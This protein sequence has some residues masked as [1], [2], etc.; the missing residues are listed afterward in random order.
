MKLF[1]I[2]HEKELFK[3]F[4]SYCLRNLLSVYKLLNIRKNLLRRNRNN[5]YKNFEIFG[6][7]SRKG[8]LKINNSTVCYESK[9]NNEERD[10]KFEISI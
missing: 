8:S 1:E 6:K 7:P 10:K 4:C 2:S 5:T 9:Q 3:I